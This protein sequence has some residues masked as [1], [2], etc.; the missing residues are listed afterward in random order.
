QTNLQQAEI[1]LK[2]L[3]SKS[4]DPA[5]A[6]AQ[7]ETTD[8]LPDPSD[9]DIPKLDE[10]FTT[11]LRNRPELRQQEGTV[12]NEEVAVHF[13][14]QALKPTFEIFGELSSASLSGTQIIPGTAGAPP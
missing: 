10:A 7:I 8:H 11:A 2:T 14:K 4:M 5:L 3:F 6:A 9:V 13:S 12:L 1:Q